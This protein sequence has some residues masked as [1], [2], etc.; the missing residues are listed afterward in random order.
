[1]K[2]IW[3]RLGRAY[4]IFGISLLRGIFW[5]ETLAFQ[6]TDYLPSSF[7]Q[8]VKIG[9]QLRHRLERRDNFDFNDSKDDAD[10]FHLIRLRLNFDFMF[11]QA[12]AGFIQLQDSRIAES[13]FKNQT[14]YEDEFDIRQAYF[15]LKGGE[16]SLQVGRQEFIYDDERLLGGFNWSNVA[17]SFDALRAIYKKEAL[18]LDAFLARKVIIDSDDLNEQNDE[19]DLFGI[20]LQYQGFEEHSLDIYYLFRETDGPVSFGPSGAKNMN[21]STLGFRLQREAS[22]GRFDYLLESA[23]QFGDFGDD[24][25]KAYAWVLQLGYTFDLESKFRL[26]LEWDFASGD[27]DPNDGERNVFDNLWPTNHLHYGYM[28][29]VSWQNLNNL[30]VTANLNPLKKLSFQMDVHFLRLDETRDAFYNAGR[31]AVRTA[32][33]E[34]DDYLGTEVDLTVKYSFNQKIKMLIGYSHFFPGNY[35][36]ETGADDPADFFYLQTVFNF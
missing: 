17:Q 4:L 11:N 1:M 9:G 14:A 16:F 8:K 34:V 13:E 10:T 33:K 22:P 18:Q 3:D 27:E 25:I 23:Y 21:E 35:L 12:L 19:D 26:G 31:K 30:R 36:E 7:T 24:E 5:K 2:L 28:D 32:N 15:R 20:Y 29:F 6:L